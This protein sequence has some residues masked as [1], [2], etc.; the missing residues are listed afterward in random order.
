MPSELATAL[1]NTKQARAYFAAFTPSAQQEYLEW[2]GSAR[3]PQTRDRRVTG[4]SGLAVQ[5][6]SDSRR[7]NEKYR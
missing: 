1:T 5:V 7:Y 3:R 2:I 6:V 4:A